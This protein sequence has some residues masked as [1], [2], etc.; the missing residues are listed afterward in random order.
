M[1]LSFAPELVATGVAAADDPMEE[2]HRTDGPVTITG[3]VRVGERLAWIEHDR[4]Q[5]LAAAGVDRALDAV[6]AAIGA[7]PWALFP[8]VSDHGTAVFCNLVG[9]RVLVDMLLP[10][11]TVHGDGRPALVA[12]FERLGEVL[13][14]IHD[15]RRLGRTGR[16]LLRRHARV[17][18]LARLLDRG[19][20][21]P[22]PT[23]ALERLQ[24]TALCEQ[25]SLTAAMTELCAMWERC[26]NSAVLHG[27]FCP[28]YVA[29]PDGPLDPQRLQ[30]LGWYDSAFGP[31]AFDAGWLLGEL[32]ELAAARADDDP[33]GYDVLRECG[34]RFLRAYLDNRPGVGASAFIAECERFA[35]MKIVSHIVAFVRGYG[36]DAEAV[37]TQ[38][39]LAAAVLDAGWEPPA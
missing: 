26:P 8:V 34:R 17:D 15:H 10:G 36:F 24:E 12:V 14:R 13:A 1:Q 2:L 30:L 16:A 33:A 4:D 37:A 22:Q 21:T 25:R 11:I 38:L 32:R 23:L 29:V 9:Q 28:G 20:A 5:R 7:E 18:E 3:C 31:P 39:A 19:R 35:A 27:T 6:R